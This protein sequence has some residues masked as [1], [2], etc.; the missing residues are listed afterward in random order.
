MQ[1]DPL[2]KSEVTVAGFATVCVQFA[3]QRTMDAMTK[4][5]T[6]T[7]A[8]DHGTIVIHVP[9]PS[10]QMAG[11]LLR[12]MTATVD[13]GC[14]KW[15]QSV[16][17]CYQDKHGRDVQTLTSLTEA[18]DIMVTHT[19]VAWHGPVVALQWLHWEPV[20]TQCRVHCTDEP[21][22]LLRDLHDREDNV[23]QTCIRQCRTF[24]SPGSAWAVVVGLQ[25][26]AV[27]MTDALMAM[28]T[29]VAPDLF[30][31]VKAQGLRGAVAKKDARYVAMDA[32]L[33]LA[34]ILDVT[35][36]GP[37]APTLYLHKLPKAVVLTE[38]GLRK[39]QS[40]GVSQEKHAVGQAATSRRQR[41]PR[42][43]RVSSVATEPRDTGK[44]Q[45]KVG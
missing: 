16:L 7:C 33:K 34:Y 40:L 17:R 27:T 22:V 4:C 2:K 19:R 10:E 42:P 35:L 6:D 36:V 38:D 44:L 37:E 25:W 21:P 1:G 41:A 14:T 32:L 31:Q 43:P 3:N 24:T 39:Q 45:S 15:K 13:L 8:H 11:A 12:K 29:C 30:V 9:V 20:P 26:T 23:A 28:R 5:V 18:D